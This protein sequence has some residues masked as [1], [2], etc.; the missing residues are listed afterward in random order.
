MGGVVSTDFKSSNGIEISWLVQVLLNFYWFQG[1][2]P[3]VGGRWVDRVGVGMGVWECPMHIC[4]CMYAH[5]CMLNMINMD[6]SMLAAI[7]N[8]YTCIHVDVCACTC[9][10]VGTPPCPRYPHLPPR[11]SHREPKTPKFS[12]SWTNR[13][14]SILFEESLALNTPELT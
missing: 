14:K 12:M 11:K 2:H 13:D 3:P 1:S 5:T 7:C 10:C 6:A 4:M 9:A 8:F